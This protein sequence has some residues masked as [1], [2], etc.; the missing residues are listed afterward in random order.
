MIAALAATLN[1]A[2]S[3]SSPIPLTTRHTLPRPQAG[4]KLRILLAE[5]NPVNQ[6]LAVRPLEKQG[7]AVSVKGNGKQAVEAACQEPF[8]LILM[9]IQ[10]PEMDGL[11]ATAQIREHERKTGQH[12]PIIAMTAHAMQGDRERFWQRGWTITFQSRL[13]PT[14]S[15]A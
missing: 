4:H 12:M 3:K 14:N 2:D 5:D 15:T 1:R 10:M 11:Q 9:D 7:F 8:D 6:K 13:R